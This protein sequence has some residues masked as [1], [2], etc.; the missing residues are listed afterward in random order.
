M[1]KIL[2]A[3]LLILMLFIIVSCS[4]EIKNNEAS[5]RTIELSFGFVGEFDSISQTPIQARA[6]SRSL[7]EATTPK[8]WY[9]IQVYDETGPYAYGFFDNIEDMKLLCVKDAKYSFTVD[10]VPE[11]E[12]KVFYFS[13][14][15]SGWA[16]IGNSFY[17]SKTES[18]RYL[19]KGYL[20]MRYPICDTFNR[21]AIDRFYGTLSDYTATQNGKVNISLTRRA[22]SSKF[23]AKE[24]T[25]GTLEISLDNAP[26]FIIKANE[27]NEFEHFYSFNNLSSASEEIGVSIVWVNGE[28]KRIP[29]VAQNVNFVRNTL[30][31][32][33]FTVKATETSNTFSLSADEQ[34]TD[35][36]TIVL[37]NVDDLVNT[38]VE[39]DNSEE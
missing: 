26:K 28:G 12:E 21:P 6:T 3:I 7:D 14:V 20:Y 13:L 16:S 34:L 39:T 32:L 25:E 9:A 27:T 15:Q 30:T 36:G 10:M 23:I 8:N 19:G 31:T 38:E 22:F 18:V 29:I 2:S 37:D 4:N 5:E 17:Y 35:G 24:F 33:E 11:A 1:K